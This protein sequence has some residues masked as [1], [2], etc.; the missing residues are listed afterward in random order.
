MNINSM[1]DGVDF[2][3][4]SKSN[5][6]DVL[7]EGDYTPPKLNDGKLEVVGA[8]PPAYLINLIVHFPP[9]AW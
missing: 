6:D 3:G 7:Q 1:A 8:S 5:D 2:F 4:T 9:V